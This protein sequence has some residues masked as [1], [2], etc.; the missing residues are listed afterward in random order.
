VKIVSLLA[1]DFMLK[2]LNGIELDTEGQL[3][4]ILIS[5]LYKYFE[6]SITLCVGERSTFVFEQRLSRLPY[7]KGGCASGPGIVG[8]WGCQ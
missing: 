7:M 5:D 3:G 6:Q 1:Y 2:G 4:P 8:A